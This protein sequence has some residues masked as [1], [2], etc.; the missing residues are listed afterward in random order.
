MEQKIK[1]LI[2]L[3]ALIS[4]G[5]AV[6]MQCRF[7]MREMNQLPYTYACSSEGLSNISESES[8]T[9]VNGTH[10]SG[11]S[12]RDVQFLFITSERGLTFFPR[13]IDNFFPNLIAIG[14]QY[15]NIS[16]LN[17]DELNAFNNLTWMALSNQP[18]LERI[19]GNFFANTPQMKTIFVYQNPIKYIGEGLLDSLEFLNY[20]HFGNNY[21][22]NISA[23]NPSEIPF[24]IE[25]L[26][27]NCS[28]IEIPTST[29]T[30]IVTTEELPSCTD[31]D[32]IICNLQEQNIILMQQNEEITSKIV[33]M[34]MTMDELSASNS[35]MKIK[36]EEISSKNS[37]TNE[38]LEKL[39]HENS[40]L[41]QKLDE[42]LEGILELS[43]RPCGI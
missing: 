41:N 24:L 36:L 22:V 20:A 6:K 30:E 29:T 5:F 13:N 37:K 8:L 19:P 4:T 35:D 1:F 34:S 39:S 3:Q 31:M 27:T 7:E 15:C 12:N 11:K 9:A 32:E 16:S 26:R 17:G 38:K 21:C 42:V 10:M 23:E 28:D 2:F 18:V 25:H 33:E 43:T 14:F 40:V